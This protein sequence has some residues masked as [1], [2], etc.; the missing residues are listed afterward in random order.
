VVFDRHCRLV[1]GLVFTASLPPPSLRA[2]W[3]LAH[4]T[5]V[6]YFLPCLSPLLCILAYLILG[7]VFDDS[8]T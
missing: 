5:H 8:L 2:K 1:E 3:L 4:Q 7:G 6:W